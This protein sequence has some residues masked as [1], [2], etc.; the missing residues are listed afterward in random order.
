MGGS[1]GEDKVGG[2]VE[3]PRRNMRDQEIIT[4][5]VS[6][7]LMHIDLSRCHPSLDAASFS[8]AV[9][10][11]DFF[12]HQQPHHLVVTPVATTIV[13]RCHHQCPPF[14]VG[15]IICRPRCLIPLMPLL[16]SAPVAQAVVAVTVLFLCQPRCCLPPLCR[17][18]YE[19]DRP[20]RA[21]PTS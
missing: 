12:L 13:N 10:S 16:S 7:W 4:Y 18:S 2:N 19:Q 17:Q 21:S 8:T 15:T 5:R 11:C 1:T 3:T 14:S 20:G 9:A 6:D